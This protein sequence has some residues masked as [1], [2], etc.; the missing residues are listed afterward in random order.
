MA[1][2]IST[3]ADSQEQWRPVPE[4]EGLY[5][6][7]NLGRLRRDCPAPGARAGSILRARGKYL[8]CALRKDGKTYERKIHQLVAAV[9]IGPCPQG[10][11]VNHKDANRKNNV[12]GNLEYTTPLENTRHAIGLGLHGK[13]VLCHHATLDNRRVLEIRH[14]LATTNDS[15]SAIAADYNVCRET[16]TQIS[17]RKTWTHI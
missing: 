14:R 1:E 9:F 10:M 8:G 12:S 4:F 7:S 16:I 15:H 3:P 6:I 17:N 11:Q 2:H 5:S 13:G